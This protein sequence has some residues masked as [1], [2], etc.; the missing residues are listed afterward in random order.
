[1]KYKNCHTVRSTTNPHPNSQTWRY[2]E[3]GSP[4][5]NPTPKLISGQCNRSRDGVGGTGSDYGKLPRLPAFPKHFSAASLKTAQHM[6]RV[7]I[8][9]CKSMARHTLGVTPTWGC[10]NWSHTENSPKIT[11]YI[12]TS[13]FNMHP[14]HREVSAQCPQWSWSVLPQTFCLPTYQKGKTPR[15][16]RAA[17]FNSTWERGKW[18]G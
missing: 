16:A 18:K 3:A 17:P 7:I 9:S 10:A 8:D 4:E 1:M 15:T 6:A 14:E 11:N 12:R 2:P 5:P 13:I